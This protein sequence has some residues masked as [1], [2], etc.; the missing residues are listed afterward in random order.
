MGHCM[1]RE[2]YL[3]N[4]QDNRGV[5]RGRRKGWREEKEEKQESIQAPLGTMICHSIITAQGSQA[6]RHCLRQGMW[7]GLDGRYH[8]HV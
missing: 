2:R 6:Q 7:E 4:N 8:G 1:R 3:G 5:R